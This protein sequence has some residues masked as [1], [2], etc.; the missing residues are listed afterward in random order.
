MTAMLPVDGWPVV[1][2][3]QLFPPAEITGAQPI[4]MGVLSDDIAGDGSLSEPMLGFRISEGSLSA[5]NGTSEIMPPS[6]IL[7]AR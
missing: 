1:E 5:M 6:S 3:L 2:S 7:L 4:K